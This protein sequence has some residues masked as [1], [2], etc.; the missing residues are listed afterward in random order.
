MRIL[1]VDDNRSS[2]DAIV[3]ALRKR[4]D[5]AHAAYDGATAIDQI[6]R[7]RPDVV[8]TDLRM[9][10]VDGMEVLRA[11]RDVRPLIEVIVFTAYGAVDT[12]VEAMHLGARDFLTKPVTFDQ[13][14][15]TTEGI[16]S[17]SSGG[18]SPDASTRDLDES[19]STSRVRQG[20]VRDTPARRRGSLSRLARRRARCGPW[21]R[22]VHAPPAGQSRRAFRADG[23]QPRNLVA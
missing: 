23:C 22:R 13:L 9:E 3:K 11:A 20:T 14:S 1:V 12:A 10:P 21:S 2:A 15:E 4:G 16:A 17:P 18:P 19:F 7:T 5:D 8:L 6:E